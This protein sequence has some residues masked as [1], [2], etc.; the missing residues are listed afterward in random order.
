MRTKEDILSESQNW[1]SKT[2]VWDTEAAI[3]ERL[4]IEVLIDIRD[5]LDALL[6]D[7]GTNLF[8]HAKES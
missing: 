3:N 1:V 2:P 5:I 7:I 4:T 6:K 8:D